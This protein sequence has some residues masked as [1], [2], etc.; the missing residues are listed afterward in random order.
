MVLREIKYWV[1]LW[2]LRFRCIVEQPFEIISSALTGK[3]LFLK[4]ILL[5]PSLTTLD[6]CVLENH[7][8]ELAPNF[9]ADSCKV[10]GYST[11]SN[12]SPLI[13]KT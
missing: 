10:S 4:S 6:F 11:T 5:F 3:Q 8:A 12:Y 7:R 9:A 2:L 1:D 13:L